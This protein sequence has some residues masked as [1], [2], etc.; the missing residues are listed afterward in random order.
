MHAKRRLRTDA[1]DQD[2]TVARAG[3]SKLTIM[4]GSSDDQRCAAGN[5][6]FLFFR[7]VDRVGDEDAHLSLRGAAPFRYSRGGPPCPLRRVS[8]RQ[9]RG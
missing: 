4:R 7:W 8:F 5:N 2:F 9:R 3:A 6:K 1:L